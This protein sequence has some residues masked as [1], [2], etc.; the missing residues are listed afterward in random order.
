MG[1]WEFSGWEFIRVGIFRVA[2]FLV[3]V[4]QVGVFWVGVYRVGV[5][6]VGIFL[7]PI[8]YVV[9]TPHANFSLMTLINKESTTCIAHNFYASNK[10]HF[11]YMKLQ[12]I[13]I[14]VIVIL[15][16]KN[17]ISTSLVCNILFLE[18]VYKF[19]KVS[20]SKPCGKYN[21]KKC[22]MTSL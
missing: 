7:V 9:D 2:I 10:T 20:V 15:I 8:F 3:G 11:R 14:V 19:G 4:Y 21:P 16:N 13:I 18:V 6:Q 5:F 17:I 22:P 12:I 1:G